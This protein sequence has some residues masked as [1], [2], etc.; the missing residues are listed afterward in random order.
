[1]GNDSFYFGQPLATTGIDRITDFSP[2]LDK[3]VL[4]SVIY[5]SLSTN[6]IRVNQF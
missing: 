2:N 1:M 4:S 6:G 3:L 5:S